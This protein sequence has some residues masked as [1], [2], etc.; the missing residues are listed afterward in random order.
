MTVKQIAIPIHVE[1]T[2]YEAPSEWRKAGAIGKAKHIIELCKQHAIFPNNILEIGAGDGAVLSILDSYDFCANMYALEVSKSGVDVING[3]GIK[4][5]RE[6]KLFDGYNLEYPDNYFDLVYLTHVLEHV[7]YERVLLRELLRVGRHHI[8]EVPL[9]INSLPNEGIGK[10]LLPSYGHI[11][12]YTP[13]LLKFLLRTED[14]FIIDDLLGITCFEA[15]SHMHFE[16]HGY[17]KNE[18]AERQLFDE[19]RNKEIAFSRLDRSEQERRS[20]F[21]TVLTRAASKLDKK[22]IHLKD[23]M[24]LIE[25]GQRHESLLILNAFYHGKDKRAMA[26]SV[27]KYCIQ[28]NREDDATFF[29]Q[30]SEGVSE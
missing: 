17:E 9:D 30:F 20:S 2:V 19:H 7:E 5:L 1:E 11:N 27:A 18:I 26:V 24:T 14:F 8:I 29:I 15:I 23:M 21:Y 3:Q 28:K 4:N 12:V 16:F 6:C 10:S 13:D 22:N 25:K